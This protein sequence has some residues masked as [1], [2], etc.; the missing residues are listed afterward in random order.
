M[1]HG[2]QLGLWPNGINHRLRVQIAVRVDLDPFQ[3]HPLP[4]A[5]EMPGDDVGVMLHHDST[6][7]SPGCRRG[8]A[9]A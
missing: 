7:S 8:A 1:R 5:Q 4:L 9:Q 2:Y 3:H 6:I